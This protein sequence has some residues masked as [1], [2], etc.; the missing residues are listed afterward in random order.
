LFNIAEEQ[1]RLNMLLEENEGEITP[2]LEKLLAVNEANLYTKAANYRNAILNNAFIIEMAKAEKKRLDT[3]IKKKEHANDVMKERIKDAMN[4][5]GMSRIDIDK[6]VGGSFSFRK[7]VS[8][9]IEEGK[10][11]EVPES[12]REVT[13]TLDKTAIK[14]A[15]LAGEE[16]EHAWLEE[17]QNLQIK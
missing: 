8:T 14:E 16:V 2:E 10:E 4:L 3:L 13:W 6:G 11:S 12:F 9:A 17:R 7:S 15:L 5:F 1:V